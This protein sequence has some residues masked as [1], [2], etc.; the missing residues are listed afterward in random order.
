MD[1]FSRR[2]V[3][4][5]REGI[6][7][8]IRVPATTTNFGPGFDAFGA[9]LRLYNWT[10]LR[11]GTGVDGVLSPMVQEAADAFFRAAGLSNFPFDCRIS[12]E[13]PCARGLGSSATVRIGVLVGLNEI[14]GRPLSR[15]QLL[16]L[17]SSLE[18]HPDN[19]A[20]ALLGGFTISTDDG[21][22][23][24][25]IGRRLEFVAFVPEIE[26]ETEWARA[27][28]P[29]S[30]SLR[31][32]VWN[33]QRAA[34]IA[35]TICLR[36]YE[37]LRGLF[38]D[39]WHEPVRVR[40]IVGWEAVRK[41]AYEAG[42]IGFYLSGAGSTLMGLAAG[43]GAEVAEAMARTAAKVGLRGSCRRMGAENLGAKAWMRHFSRPTAQ[44]ETDRVS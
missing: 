10:T 7:C 13:V 31:D 14:S 5:E 23:R 41:S 4:E 26:M 19:V 29:Q 22:T 11:V 28:L 8:R 44:G 20:A 12:G 42:A 21:Q 15:R 3:K 38:D 1:S 43:R 2:A 17:G 16:A 18:G 37:E 32:A 35:A 9:A 25:P 30:V 36:R 6:E 27:V 39:R 24:V 33:L 40:R 34:R